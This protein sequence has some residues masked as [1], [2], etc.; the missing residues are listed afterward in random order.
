MIRVEKLKNGLGECQV[1]LVA[2]ESIIFS[3][4]FYSKKNTKWKWKKKKF[5]LKIKFTFPKS[6]EGTRVSVSSKLASKI[7]VSHPR[8]G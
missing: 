6:T 2:E 4:V 1:I 7:I 5:Q 8:P 3:L